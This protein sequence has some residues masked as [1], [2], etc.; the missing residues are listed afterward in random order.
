[1]ILWCFRLWCIQNEN[2]VLEESLTNLKTELEVARTQM[3]SPGSNFDFL[4]ENLKEANEKI[5]EKEQK[6]LGLKSQVDK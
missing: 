3:A 2:A 6:I 5:V 4:S 1:M